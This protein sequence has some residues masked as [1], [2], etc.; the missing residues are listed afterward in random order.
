M[1]NLRQKTVS[2]FFWEITGRFASQGISI[3]VTII[4]ARLVAPE[5]FGSIAVVLVLILFAGVIVDMGFSAAIIQRNDL[6]NTHYSSIFFLNITISV[7]LSLILFISPRKLL[8][9]IH[10]S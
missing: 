2:A 10:S 9:R 3:I 8:T 1:K 6:T 5:E 7:I 4:L